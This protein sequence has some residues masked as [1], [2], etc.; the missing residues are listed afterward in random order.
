MLFLYHSTSVTIQ[1]VR[2]AARTQMY[3][4]T[5]LHISILIDRCLFTPI[6]IIIIIIIIMVHHDDDRIVSIIGMDGYPIRLSGSGRISTIRHNPPPAGLP[7]SR[8]IG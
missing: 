8:R 4:L 5:Y 1:A 7:V 2:I 3:L 6:I